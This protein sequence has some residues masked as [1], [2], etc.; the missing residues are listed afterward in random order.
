V[1][2]HLFVAAPEE[3]LVLVLVEAEQR[4]RSAYVAA[5]V[6]EALRSKRV[7]GA[8]GNLL[9]LVVP[10]IGVAE[11]GVARIEIS[12]AMVLLAAALAERFKDGRPLAYSAP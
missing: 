4:D 9:R 1:L 6:I 5:D 12:F 8:A 7:G 3:Q 10:V 11:P 2:N